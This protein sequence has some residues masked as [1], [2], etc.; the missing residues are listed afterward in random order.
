[1][2]AEEADRAAVKQAGLAAQQR[3]EANEQAGLEGVAP[4]TIK[5]S[6]RTVT[7]QTTLFVTSF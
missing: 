1:M 4:S 7:V 6:L 3:V 5:V 2:N